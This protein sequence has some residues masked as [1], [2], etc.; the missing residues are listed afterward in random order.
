[1]AS[2]HWALP[3]RFWSAWILDTSEK[4]P[5][6]STLL[7]WSQE[8]SNTSRP[9]ENCQQAPESTPAV[10]RVQGVP[11][12]LEI[13]QQVP[14]STSALPGLQ[15]VTDTAWDLWVD[16]SWFS[17]PDTLWNL[18]WGTRPCHCCT[19]SAGIPCA[20]S[21]PPPASLLDRFLYPCYLRSRLE[22]A[23]HTQ[24]LGL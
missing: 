5:V 9:C 17:A 14:D 1:M 13:S 4:L 8:L 3:L 22:W 16:T 19:E 21:V 18:R 7:P 6:G 11:D 23:A 12:T 15:R 10:L 24:R 2:W 20:W